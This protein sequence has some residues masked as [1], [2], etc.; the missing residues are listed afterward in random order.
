VKPN[1]LSNTISILGTSAL[2][3]FSFPFFFPSTGFKKNNNTI[4]KAIFKIP[5]I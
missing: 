1:L 2:S 4:K 3:A 5:A